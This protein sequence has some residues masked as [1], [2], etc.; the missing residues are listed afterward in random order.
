MKG[1]CAAAEEHGAQSRAG[2]VER[3]QWRRRGWKGQQG[4]MGTRCEDN[5]FNPGEM[6]LEQKKVKG[7]TG[8]SDG[9]V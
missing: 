4:R 9:H 8:R 6:Q 3:A 2:Y 7:S 1:I 5:Y